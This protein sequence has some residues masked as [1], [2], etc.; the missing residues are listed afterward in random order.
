MLLRLFAVE[1]GIV[2]TMDAHV[3]V[4]I[5]DVVDVYGRVVF[6]PVEFVGAAVHKRILRWYLAFLA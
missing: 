4:A 2:L 6:H 3:V 1:T 5:D